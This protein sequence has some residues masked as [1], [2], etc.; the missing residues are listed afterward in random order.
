MATTRQQSSR[1]STKK[2]A[3]EDALRVASLLRANLTAGKVP[4]RSQAGT[5]PPPSNPPST[6]APVPPGMTST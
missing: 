1:S 3:N 2:P 6:S 5:T 4:E